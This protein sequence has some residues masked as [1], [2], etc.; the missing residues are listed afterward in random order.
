MLWNP[1]V[2]AFWFYEKLDLKCAEYIKPNY[3]E[4]KYKGFLVN[5]RKKHPEIIYSGDSKY[6]YTAESISEA[7][8]NFLRTQLVEPYLTEYLSLDLIDKL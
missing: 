3:R 5:L 7:V 6:A 4:W 8:H 2:D 1:V